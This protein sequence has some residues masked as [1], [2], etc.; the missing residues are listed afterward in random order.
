[1]HILLGASLSVAAALAL[2]L[3]T[4]ARSRKQPRYTTWEEFMR[5]W[6]EGDS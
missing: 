6:N 4:V 3:V 2:V 1:M 5:A